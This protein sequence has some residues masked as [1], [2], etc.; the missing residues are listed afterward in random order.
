MLQRKQNREGKTEVDE[1]CFEVFV[2]PTLDCKTSDDQERANPDDL[3]TTNIFLLYN[4]ATLF[5][6]VLYE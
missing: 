4:A 1:P 2:Q 6:A 5:L 3:V